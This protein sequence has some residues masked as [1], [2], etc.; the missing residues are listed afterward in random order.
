MSSKRVYYRRKRKFSRK[1]SLSGLIW[2]LIF[3]FFLFL[4]SLAGFL[5]FSQNNQGKWESEKIKLEIQ[6]PKTLASGQLADFTLLLKNGGDVAL[7]NAELSLSFPQNFSFVDAQPKFSQSLSTGGLWSLKKVSPHQT[8]KIKIKGRVFGQE[9]EE[10]IFN[11]ALNYQ[12]ENFSSTFLET[13]SAKVKVV[14]SVIEIDFTLPQELG[15]SEEL[16]GEIKVKKNPFL[17]QEEIKNIKISLDYPQDFQIEKEENLDEE[18]TISEGKE[19]QQIWLI[20]DLSSEKLLTFKGY[21]EN[22]E[23]KENELEKDFLLRVFFLND[24]GQESPLI[25]QKEKKVKLSVPLL[26]LDLKIND[27]EKNEQVVDLGDSLTYQISYQNLSQEEINNL[28]LE[29]HF[30]GDNLI[31]KGSL[32]LLGKLIGED[33][34]GIEQGNIFVFNKEKVADFEKLSS[35]AKGILRFKVDLKEELPDKEENPYFLTWLK[36]SADNLELE[37]SQ[38]KFK[39]KGKVSLTAE[40]HY[41]SDNY[42]QV[43]SGP[44]P[45]R[46]GEMTGYQIELT[47]KNG[48]NKLK[49]IQIKT[50][51][52]LEATWL[53]EENSTAGKID[54]SQDLKLVN[55]LIKSLSPYETEKAVFKVGIQPK[56]DDLGK[57]I[58]LTKGSYLKAQ[59]DFVQEEITLQSEPISTDLP[60]DPLAQ[61]RGVVQE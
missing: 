19:N 33:V 11:L 22:K 3:I 26:K 17:P 61:G 29:V 5:F 37:T 44:L 23:R 13:A 42:Q 46:V 54:F 36:A 28:V 48:S 49:D 45:P 53:G 32:K 18:I 14:S 10:K 15:L 7:N 50:P 51:L 6:G 55:W 47:L 24:E 2:G 34:S 4:V 30:Q 58:L 9:G 20:K 27:S 25:V 60:N 39:V 8:I 57:I 43:G 40:G 41:F 38:I 21:F 35:Q 1:T 59:D 52:S 12:P 56:R 16:T 31:K